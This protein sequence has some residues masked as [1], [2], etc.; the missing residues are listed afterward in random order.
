[1]DVLAANE[2]IIRLSVFLGVLALMLIVEWWQPFRQQRLRRQQRWPANILIVAMDTLLVRLLIPAGAVGA[3]LW[4][5]SQGLGLFQQFD[6]GYVAPLLLSVLVL[7]LSIYWQHR[8]FHQVPWLWRLHRVHHVDQ[9]IDTTTGFRFHPLEIIL[10]MFIKIAVVVALGAPAEAVILFEIILS[11]TSLFNH[12]NINL[13]ARAEPWVRAL[14]VTPA[15]HRIHHSQRVEETN[16]NYGFNLTLWDRLFRSY[17]ATA[18]G[19]EAGLQIG[20]K[21]FQNAQQ[22]NRL[23]GML[24]LPFR[25]KP[26]TAPQATRKGSG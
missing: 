1:M 12:A 18:K 23:W 16:S 8:I 6:M 22:T 19:G 3:A 24:L 7:D 20:I 13:P 11:A 17:T 21:E 9:D 25:N 5:Q 2:P 4:A 14:I 15:M 10:S 26:D